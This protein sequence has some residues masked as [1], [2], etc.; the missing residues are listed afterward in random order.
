MT[1]LLIDSGNSRIK[2]WF[3]SEAQ[4]V[5]SNTTPHAADLYQADWLNLL[6][7][8]W[9]QQRQPSR[10]I[11]SHVGQDQT[12]RALTQLIRDVFDATVITL[13]T[14][15][16]NFNG[17]QLNYNATSMGSDR[18]A[19]LLGAHQLNLSGAYLVV[20][21]GTAIT[22][23]GVLTGGQHVGGMILPSID[24]MRRSLH[25]Y[26]A[27]LPLNGGMPAPKQAPRATDDALATGALLAAVGAIHE[28]A[29]RYMHGED[30]T[31]ILCGGGAGQIAPYIRS[32]MIQSIEPHVALCLYGLRSYIQH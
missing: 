32:P 12:L 13:L 17:F 5:Q 14:V 26:T 16:P 11:I 30:L 24:L 2:W 29:A 28:F 31:L 22:V 27:K 4:P 8:D 23:D 18:Y 7:A 21:A 6:R 19:Q 1:T 10:C 9:Q 20:S 3:H 25:Q 15:Q